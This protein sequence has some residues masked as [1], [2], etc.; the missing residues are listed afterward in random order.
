MTEEQVGQAFLGDMHRLFGK[1][2]VLWHKVFRLPVSGIVYHKG[3][4]DHIVPVATP[5][6]NL[7][8]AGIF[9]SYPERGIDRSAAL[10]RRIVNHF[11][12]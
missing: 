5:I 9:N 12:K 10:V 2:E 7:F 1:Q 3:I 6:P 4:K 11:E 8:V